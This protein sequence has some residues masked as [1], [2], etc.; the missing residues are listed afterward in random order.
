MAVVLPRSYPPPREEDLK[1]IVPMGIVS[2]RSP[3]DVINIM[4]ANMGFRKRKVGPEHDEKGAASSPS[5]EDKCR[6]WGTWAWSSAQLLRRLFSRDGV[7]SWILDPE[8]LRKSS[9]HLYFQTT[10]LINTV[11]LLSAAYLLSGVFAVTLG[12]AIPVLVALNFTGFLLNASILAGMRWSNCFDQASWSKLPYRLQI[13][14]NLLFGLVIAPLYV[15]N[16]FTGGIGRMTL[17]CQFILPLLCFN[18]TRSVRATAAWTSI[19]IIEMFHL[20]RLWTEGTE[21]AHYKPDGSNLVPFGGLLL[22]ICFLLIYDMNSYNREL[23]HRLEEQNKQIISALAS[24]GSA[25]SLARTLPVSGVAKFK[26]L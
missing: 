7:S 8:M 11:A 2:R 19:I 21:W 14:A 24:K 3:A 1:P 10:T 13:L 5:A 17:W 25:M 12:R 15:L 9:L 18:L 22:C 16:T 26:S 23:K 20:K 4:K 6:R